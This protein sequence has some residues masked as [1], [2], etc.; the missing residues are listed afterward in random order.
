MIK[1]K[2]TLFLIFP[3]VCLFLELLPTGVVLNFATPYGEPRRE[4]VS[5]FSPL[6]YGYGDFGPILTAMLTIVLLI[7]ALIYLFLPRRGVNTA[8]AGLSACGIITS[9]MPLMF[10][11]YNATVIGV[12]I[13]ALLV[14]SAGVSFIQ[15]K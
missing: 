1:L 13:T 9:L 8:I 6:A 14:G 3:A 15:S 5:Y 2:K 10:G 12:L 11:L 7:L 4:T